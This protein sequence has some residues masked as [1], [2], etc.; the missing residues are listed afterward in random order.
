MLSFWNRLI[1]LH[2]ERLTRKTFDIDYSLALQGHHNWCTSV[3]N[4]MHALGIEQVFY[5]KTVCDMSN[6]KKLLLS[7]E[8][9][10]WKVLLVNK[11]KL[12]FY[13]IFK[14]TFKP[15]TYVKLN[16]SVHER[17]Q[18]A[19]LRFGILPLKVET[20]RFSNTP[21]EDRKCEM[22][23]ADEIEDECHFLF[24]CERYSDI[25]NE[26]EINVRNNLQNFIYM[27]VNDQL[28]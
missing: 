10:D 9:E 2:E 21:L 1:N 25:R 11:P 6:C 16:L 12:R 26:W 5:N 4:I 8:E 19:Q 13:R 17:S 22:C 27:E 23:N 24:E 20:G 14:N 15:E 18:L 28:K 3:F 7:K